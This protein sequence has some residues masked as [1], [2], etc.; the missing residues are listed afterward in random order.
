M[1]GIDVVPRRRSAVTAAL[2]PRLGLFSAIAIARVGP[3][4]IC[5]FIAA[6]R[7]S[8]ASWRGSICKISLQTAIAWTRKPCCAYRSAARVNASIASLSR[9][10]RR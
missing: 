5:S 8:A 7:W 3:A 10:S 9:F 2:S 6:I 1:S 4:P